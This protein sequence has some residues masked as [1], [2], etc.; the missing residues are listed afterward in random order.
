MSTNNELQLLETSLKIY[1]AICVKPEIAYLWLYFFELFPTCD[2]AL[3]NNI[4]WLYNY[5]IDKGSWKS[6][7]VLRSRTLPVWPLQ[8]D[9]CTVKSRCLTFIIKF[10]LDACC[11]ELSH[12]P[13]L[14]LCSNWEGFY[15]CFKYIQLPGSTYCLSSLFIAAFD[16]SF[17][18]AFS[19]AT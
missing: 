4:F 12:P 17:S 16:R 11:N 10:I 3:L 7:L 9:V 15:F 13:L 1:W 2:H 6:R 19:F 14:L 5:H 8:F 18:Q